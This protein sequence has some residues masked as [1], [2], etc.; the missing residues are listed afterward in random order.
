MGIETA[1]YLHDIGKIGV[2]DKILLKPTSLSKNEREVIERHP[3]ISYSILKPINFPWDIATIVRHHHEHFNGD[4]YV[5]GKKGDEIPIGSRI[6]AVA[7]AFEAMTSERPYRKAKTPIEALEELVRCAGTQFDPTV[8]KTF[9]KIWLDQAGR[10]DKELLEE[11][12]M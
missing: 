2:E 7:D 4:G 3:N 11:I 9:K 1:A 5:D 8:V 10:S 12:E 6:L